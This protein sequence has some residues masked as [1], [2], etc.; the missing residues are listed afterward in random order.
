MI[1][2]RRTP[3]AAV[4]GCNPIVVR[5]GGDISDPLLICQ[6]PIYCLSETRIKAFVWLPS[7]F[8]ADFTGI[9]GVAQVVPRT[10]LHE[11]NL[12]RIGFAISARPFHVKDG[13]DSL[14]DLDV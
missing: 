2:L 13:T 12:L 10:I 9:N 6:I 7:K 1:P 11:G 3:S 14:Y 8:A 5:A 4:L